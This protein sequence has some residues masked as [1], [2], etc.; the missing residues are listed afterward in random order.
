MKKF[1]QF[2]KLRKFCV[3]CS[4]V[5][6]ISSGLTYVWLIGLLV[7][8]SSGAQVPDLRQQSDQADSLLQSEMNPTPTRSNPPEGTK[9]DYTARL[10]HAPEG[11]LFRLIPMQKGITEVPGNQIQLYFQP[12]E[13]TNGGPA[14]KYFL[15]SVTRVEGRVV[16]IRVSAAGTDRPERLPRPGENSK[17]VWCISLGQPE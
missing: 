8:C 1:L 15:A 14:A 6:A 9:A 3:G 17:E 4:K 11:G 12:P 2:S 5:T 13:R 7:P 10:V 16:Y